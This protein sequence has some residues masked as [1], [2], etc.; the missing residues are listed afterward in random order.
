MRQRAAASLLYQSQHAEPAFRNLPKLI[1]L[2][3]VGRILAF[4][5]KLY[6]A[7]SS[8]LSPIQTTINAFITLYISILTNI[9]RTSK[10]QDTAAKHSSLANPNRITKIGLTG[11]SRADFL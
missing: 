8:I 10:T 4:Y 11:I 7:K 3:I 5:T 9:K 1:F 6:Q 2:K